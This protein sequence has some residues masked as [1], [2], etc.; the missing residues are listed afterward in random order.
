MSRVRVV[1][2]ALVV[3][4]ATS[5]VARAQFDR[6]TAP[7]VA[8]PTALV[9]PGD[10][11]A[12][13]LD[14]ADLAL[15]DGWGITYTHAQASQGVPGLHQGDGLYFGVPLPLGIGIGLSAERVRGAP[16]VA[17][18]ASGRLSLGLAWAADPRVAFG[19]AIRW[20]G[21]P[22][23]PLDGTT[24]FDLAMTVRPAERLGL[25]LMIHDLFGPLGLVGGGAADL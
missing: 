5:P 12:M 15:L 20:I 13:G 11:L 6:P 2:L 16:G 23:D 17:S 10:P 19:T 22:G 3:A 7:V 25:A 18:A 9:A 24:T 1:G 4:L 21:V 8:P 14:P